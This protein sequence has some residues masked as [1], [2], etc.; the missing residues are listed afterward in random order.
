VK[1]IIHYRSD[2]ERGLTDPLPEKKWSFVFRLYSGDICDPSK[3]AQLLYKESWFGPKFPSRVWRAF[4]KWPVLPFIAWRCNKHGGY[5]GFKLYGMDSS[6][7]KE[8]PV[9]IKPED[10]FDGSQ[11]LCLTFRPFAMIEE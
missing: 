10:V 3:I 5:I 9:G 1:V 11:A 7:Y 4:C 6:Q 8:W 2:P